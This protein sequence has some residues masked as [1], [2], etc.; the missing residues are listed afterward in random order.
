MTRIS[1]S[2]FILC[3]SIGLSAQEPETGVV[4]ARYPAREKISSLETAADGNLPLRQRGTP[5]ADD[6]T[7]VL[8]ER[9]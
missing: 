8:I 4:T 2:L 5:Q 7:V 1:V 9:E 6:M 3:L